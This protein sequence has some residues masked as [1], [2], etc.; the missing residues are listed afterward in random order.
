MDRR[1]A[2]VRRRSCVTIVWARSRRAEASSKNVTAK[3]SRARRNGQSPPG[4]SKACHTGQTV[5]IG[6]SRN[7]TEKKLVREFH[8]FECDL[9]SI[10]RV[11][12]SGLCVG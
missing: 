9:L 12:N 8:A 1:D 11:G 6:Q 3:S 5:A 4:E 7:F 2:Q 10:V